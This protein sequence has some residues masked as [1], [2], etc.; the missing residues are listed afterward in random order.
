MKE[1]FCPLFFIV[2]KPVPLIPLLE[3]AATMSKPSPAKSHPKMNPSP[4]CC[5][6]L[7]PLNNPQIESNRLALCIQVATQ[8]YYYRMSWQVPDS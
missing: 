7:F 5:R 3:R 6:H 2:A 8:V 4:M 1:K